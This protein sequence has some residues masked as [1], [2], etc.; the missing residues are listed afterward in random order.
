MQEEEERPLG[1]AARVRMPKAR[2]AE[3]KFIS[4]PAL[5]SDTLS[6]ALPMHLKYW[7]VRLCVCVSI[8]I[9]FL[10]SFSLINS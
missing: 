8:V 3:P 1:V 9:E 6:L 10:F 2:R 4:S 7:C 5:F